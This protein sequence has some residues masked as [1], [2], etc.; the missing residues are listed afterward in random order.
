MVNCIRTFILI[1][2]ALVLLSACGGGGGSGGGGSNSA[3]AN[4]APTAIINVSKTS[5]YAPL[6]LE[7]DG[8]QS[9]DLDGN[10]TNY[11]WDFGDG[12]ISLGSQANHTYTSL[13]LFTATL[14][15]TDDDGAN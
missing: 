15:I 9:S 4:T 13:A 11:S 3:A 5:G 8:S 6:S 2:S 12:T 1:C 10:V 7:F 14:T